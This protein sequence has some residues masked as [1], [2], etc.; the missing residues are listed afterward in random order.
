MQVADLNSFFPEPAIILDWRVFSDLSYKNLADLRYFSRLH[1]SNQK[2][3]LTS[4]FVAQ[5]AITLTI[6]LGG[7]ILS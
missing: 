3:C 4:Q 6:L 2:N 5:L 7:R 1:W